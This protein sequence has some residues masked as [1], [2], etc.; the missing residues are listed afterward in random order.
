[1]EEVKQRES[2]SKFEKQE[3]NKPQIPVDPDCQ[4]EH[5]KV[6]QDYSIALQRTDITY[7][8]ALSN[9]KL[10]KMQLLVRTDS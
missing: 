8:V 2:K 10:Y 9:D 7:G 3:C 4:I 1:V 6:Y 5:V